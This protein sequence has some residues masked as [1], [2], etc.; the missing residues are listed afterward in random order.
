LGSKIAC[1]K[2]RAAPKPENPGFGE[3]LTPGVVTPPTR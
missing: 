2:V 1:E 3:L